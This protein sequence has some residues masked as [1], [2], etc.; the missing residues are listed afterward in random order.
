MQRGIVEDIPQMN[1][2]SLG[3]VHYLPHHAVLRRDKETT[4]LRVVYD[5][6][7][8]TDGVSLNSCLHTGPS[9]LPNP[10]DI[11]VRFHLHKIA[12]IADI[13]KAI[14]MV[15]GNVE[16]RD[17]L[18]FLLIDDISKENPSLILK[19]FAMVV[20]G[21]NASPFLLDGTFKDHIS[22]YMEVDPEFVTKMLQSLYADD[23][24]TGVDGVLDGFEFYGKA[25]S[26]MKEGGLN[27]S[28]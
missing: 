25:K 17:A 12:L 3:K 8:S 7:A 6:S 4:K 27:L 11:L 10:L 21:V 26:R 9:L 13:E 18:R 2:A 28:E 24:N 15:A 19:R 5:A 22:R 14:L 16:D 23:L 20:F 1:Q